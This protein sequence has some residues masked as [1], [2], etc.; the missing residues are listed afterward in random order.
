MLDE[1]PL[2]V[3]MCGLAGFMDDSFANLQSQ[4]SQFRTRGPVIRVKNASNPQ[5][6]RDLDEHWGVFDINHLS[7][8]HLGDVRRK[9]KEIPPVAEQDA[10]DIHKQCR[11]WC[12]SSHVVG[13]GEGWTI[14]F[15]M[16]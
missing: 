4:R 7:G 2:M 10:A 16:A 1:P 5:T 11:N 3:R 12:A 13:S 14:G 15:V 8:W 6:F 9:P